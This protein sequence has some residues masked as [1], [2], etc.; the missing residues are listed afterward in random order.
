MTNPILG[1]AV[2]LL[3][4]NTK[5]AVVEKFLIRRSFRNGNLLGPQR[6]VYLDDE[7]NT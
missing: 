6:R 2:E 7:L 5:G 4:W 3:G 1:Y